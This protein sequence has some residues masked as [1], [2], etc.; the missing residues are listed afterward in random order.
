[1]SENLRGR[2]I[3][4]ILVISNN[5]HW[6]GRALQVV[7]PGFEGLEDSEELLVMCVVVQL[8]RGHGARAEDD[9]LNLAIGTGD[10]QDTSDNI[11]RSV[12]F[13]GNW[14]ARLIVSKN[15]SCCEGLF[16]PIEG[17]STVV[18]KIPRGIFPSKPS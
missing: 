7:S 3:L 10:G 17:T 5:I 14:G 15:G 18:G 4:K 16:Q 12:S 13:D 11:F 1:M 9:W 8:G 6:G 2:E